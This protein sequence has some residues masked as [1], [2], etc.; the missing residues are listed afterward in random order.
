MAELGFFV[1]GLVVTFLIS[2]LFLWLLRSWDGGATRLVAAHGA[3]W[4]LASFLAGMGMADGGAFAGARA[5]LSYAL[6]QAVWIIIDLMR[7]QTPQSSPAVEKRAPQETTSQN[8]ILWFGAA[9]A[10]MIL[11]SWGILQFAASQHPPQPSGPWDYS[12]ATPDESP[13]DAA[14]VSQTQCADQIQRLNE[15]GYTRFNQFDCFFS[16]PEQTPPN[17][18]P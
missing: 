18:T 1:S 10:G 2:R 5:A 4:I 6:P 11:V 8:Q 13:A 7:R 14:T 3:S 9:V 16:S 15:A 12:W 17:S